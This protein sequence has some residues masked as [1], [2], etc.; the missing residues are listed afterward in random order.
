M[1]IPFG[2]KVF[3]TQRNLP[4]SGTNLHICPDS[5]LHK[6][7]SFL[8]ALDHWLCVPL[9]LLYWSWLS[10]RDEP[11]EKEEE[12]IIC[13][14]IYFSSGIIYCCQQQQYSSFRWW[15]GLYNFK[16]KTGMNS[17]SLSQKMKTNTREKAS[18]NWTSNVLPLI[19]RS[20]TCNGDKKHSLKLN[21]WVSITKQINTS[22]NKYYPTA[23]VIDDAN[24]SYRDSLL[25]RVMPHGLPPSK[26]HSPGGKNNP[27]QTSHPVCAGILVWN[28][29][30]LK[31]WARRRMG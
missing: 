13:W 5:H 31:T 19:I 2:S 21:D 29:V 26:F 11:N 15:S 4:V 25:C 23:F 27:N 16:G 22:R 1:L 28:W 7:W 10:L 30:A 24:V 8:P 12:G 14:D 18:K 20:I 17:Q 6:S 3:K 9:S